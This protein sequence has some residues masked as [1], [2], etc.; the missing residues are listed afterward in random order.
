M[1]NFETRQ[2]KDDVVDG[3]SINVVLK[4]RLSDSMSDTSSTRKGSLGMFSPSSFGIAD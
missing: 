1:V 3:G 2:C 4:A